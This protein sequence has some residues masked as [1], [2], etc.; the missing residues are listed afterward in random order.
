MQNILLVLGALLL[1]VA[2]VVFAGVAVENPFARTLIL[3]LAT[4]I[5]L[6]VAPGIAKRGLTSTGETV[7][8]VGLIMLPMTLFAPVSYTHLTLPT[9][10]RV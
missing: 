9:I 4:G 5:A 8:A 2:A 6:T 3:A 7:A 10:L 1:G